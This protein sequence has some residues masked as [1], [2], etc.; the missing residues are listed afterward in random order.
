MADRSSSMAI[1][2]WMSCMLPRHEQPRLVQRHPQTPVCQ[3]SQ[4]PYRDLLLLQAALE[5]FV[6]HL[7]A[8]RKH[9]CRILV[10][11]YLA[12]L[13]RAQSCPLPLVRR[14]P[15]RFLLVLH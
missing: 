13:L 3:P 6:D 15:R 9:P 2:T 10:P 11:A 14:A 1:A 7:R 8:V 12:T 5:L 4:Q